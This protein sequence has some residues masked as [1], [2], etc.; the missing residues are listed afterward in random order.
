MIGGNGRALNRLA[1][2][3]VEKWAKTAE[4][5]AKLSDGGGLYLRKLESG[6][7]TWQLKYRHGGV[8]RTFSVGQVGLAQARQERERIKRLLKEGRDPVQARRVDRAERIASSGETFAD[9][10]QTWLKKQKPT[11]SA[12]HYDKSSKAIE[13]HVTDAI[14]KL[15]V[16]DIT[17][18]MVSSIIERVQAGGKR[19]TAAKLLQHTRAIFRLAA[20]KGLRDDNPAEAAI[21]VLAPVGN[22]KRRPALLDFASLGQ[23]LRDAERAQI[24]PGV[25]LC[26]RLI[27]FTAT[28]IANATAAKWSEFD[29]DAA[30]PIWRLP[31]DAMKVRRGRA[32]D[33]LVVLPAQIAKELKEWRQLQR[34]V[35]SPYLFPRQGNQGRGNK[36]RQPYLARE[37]V[38]KML[39]SL[40]Y[41]DRHVAHG[42]RASFST[43]AKDSG[44]FEKD[45]IN[46][47]LDHV[48]DSEVARAYD[49]GERR[50]QRVALARWWGEHLVAA[51]RVRKVVPLRRK[52]S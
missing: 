22:V 46:L 18:A 9:L 31:R 37:S 51:E 10:V 26:H 16:R 48:H 44:L 28:R 25:R 52:G 35:R 20:A 38:E 17:P 7:A 15:P 36:E 19:E 39:H 3:T 27:A 45:A 50:A 43:L 42:W 49:R 33:H 41:K 1:V 13:R 11:W 12:I 34:D 47:A 6:A 2:R 14:G 21:E 4:S 8:E 5:G 40:G 24:S 23:L 30:V 29:L 32:H